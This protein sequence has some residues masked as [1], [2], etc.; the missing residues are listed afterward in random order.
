MELSEITGKKWDNFPTNKLKKIQNK[1]REQLTGYRK[2]RKVEVVLTRILIGHTQ[3]THKHLLKNKE[4]PKCTTCS[5]IFSIEHI[6]L[7]CRDFGQIRTKYYQANN[8]EDL[9]NK[10]KPEKIIQF[11]K[12]IRLYSKIYTPSIFFF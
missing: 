11:F 6:L 1:L 2:T 3:L 9:F 8:L 12:E 5:G 10:I 4:T 7:T